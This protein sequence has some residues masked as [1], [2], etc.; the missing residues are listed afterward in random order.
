MTVL[1]CG[2]YLIHSSL[3]GD[4]TVKCIVS[5]LCYPRVRVSRPRQATRVLLAGALMAAV[6]IG[7]QAAFVSGNLVV[8]QADY[9]ASNNTTFSILELSPTTTNQATAVS[10][11]GIN[12]VSGSGSL[13]AS[14]SATSTGYLSDSDDGS[15]LLFTAHNTTN[16]SGNVNTVTA[17]AVGSLNN[18]A[19]F[20]A[21]TTY[22]GASGQQTRGACTANGSLFYIGDQGG[23][24]TNG[25][26]SALLNTNCRSVKCFG[27]TNYVFTSSASAAPV[28]QISGTTLSGLPG[29][30]SGSTS[31]Q[32]FYMISSGN[33]GTTFDTLYVL[34]ASGAATG[35]VYKYS[36]VSGS[37]VSN[38]NF[39]TS[40]GGFGLCAVKSGTG[41][42]LYVTS[43]TG[44]TAANKVMQVVDSSGYNANIFVSNVATLYTAAAG[45]TMKGI[46]FAP[47]QSASSPVLA[48]TPASLDFGSVSSGS[49]SNLDFYVSNAGQST[50]TGTVAAGGPFS[51]T[52]G[53]TFSLTAGQTS[54]VTVTFSPLSGATFSTGVVF[55]S[56][57]G[58]ATNPVT[59]IGVTP[60]SLVV[61]PTNYDFGTVATGTT[62]Q[63]SFVVSNAG[64]TAMSGT[65]AIEGS[66]AF[67]VVSGAT[68]SVA[69]YGW[70]TVAVTFT[71]T[72]A[73][74]YSGGLVLISDGG[75]TTNPLAGTGTASPIASFSGSPTSGAAPL[76]VTFTDSSAGSIT[77]R[78]WDFGD[79]TTSNTTVSSV[80]HTYAAAGSYNVALTV[81]GPGG[82]DSTTATN[83][84]VVLTP[85]HIAVLP[86]SLDFGSVVVGRTSN[87]TFQVSNSGQATL[88]G[89]ASASGPFGIVSGS[90]FTVPGGESAVVTVSFSPSAQGSFND[91]VVFASNAGGLTNSVAGLGVPAP[92][93]VATPASVDFGSVMVGVTQITSFVVSNA[94]GSVLSGS[95]SI[96]GG[97]F[98]FLSA[99][100][101]T[102][103]PSNATNLVIGFAPQSAGVF[104]T[105][106]VFSSDGGAST[107]VMTG[108]GISIWDPTPFALA[109]GDYSFTE[110]ST[111][112]PAATYPPNMIFHRAASQDPALA[113]NTLSNYFGVYNGSSG[114]R[115]NGLG[116]SGASFVNTGTGGN[117]GA[118]VLALNAS[119]RTNIQV[120][121]TGGLVA[122]ADGNRVY[123]MRLQ[124][125]IGANSWTD[126][127]G[128]VEYT[129]TNKLAGDSEVFGPLSLPDTCNNEPAVYLRW[130]YYFVSGS[131]G[132]RPQIRLD[133]IFV[134]SF[135]TSTPV[136]VLGVAPDSHDFGVVTTG[137]TATTV[138]TVTNSGGAALIGSVA[139]TGAAPFAVVGDT[140]FTVAAAGSSNITVR[141]L[142]TVAG[143]CAD[144][145]VFL[146]NGGG[147][148][149]AVTGTGYAPP[150]GYD[151]WASG[152]TNGLTNYNDCATGDGYPNLL[153]YATGSSPTNSDNLAQLLGS[154]TGG[155]FDLVFNRNTNAVDVTLVVEGRDSLVDS[156]QWNGITTN[157]NGAGWLGPATV[158]ESGSGS[159][160]R[161]TVQDTEPGAALR[162]LRLRVSRP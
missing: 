160:V 58:M 69:G 13:R 83:Y 113:V 72:A 111:T 26:S 55:A 139:V 123:A 19:T 110:W 140:N 80:Q 104:T 92:V 101:Y 41:A 100:T 32:D 49:S 68:Y 75:S 36:L 29:L 30:S 33:N 78:L 121:W 56:N 54:T 147:S 106:L 18:S 70:T 122:Q 84:I 43:G 150:S 64:S 62:A 76:V 67:V 124:Y 89:T 138:F 131:T 144:A 17:R 61:S 108:T 52:A 31:L 14:G 132:T 153:K 135:A 59:G 87:L 37:W 23:M 60:A 27:G 128:P 99:Q 98:S 105:N 97:P 158:T 137:Q 116:T 82:S 88:T 45:T 136:A 102:V 115:I 74:G 63:T 156:S 10:S 40:F 85:P 21:Q 16:T 81:T 8:F 149:N 53:S 155:V 96:A 2:G 159:P 145:L 126:V 20:A 112:N 35:I 15:L 39:G 86:S 161:V 157:Q 77:N 90:P 50:L 119:G 66:S 134:T 51:I 118:A 107:N 3:K 44:A 120:T 73:G 162:Y 95:A 151:S 91:S 28:Q 65:A 5:R 6:S 130:K 143:A 146:S 4:S 1:G 142:P 9:A 125:R 79:S 114:T 129:S 7:A 94:G 42:V 109:G 127:D 71:P 38:A 46:A 11:N 148:T 57:G 34:Y 103:Q 141:F 48:V 152:I 154:F 117:L 93:L 12:G 133:E 47:V 25:L 22:T 24:Y